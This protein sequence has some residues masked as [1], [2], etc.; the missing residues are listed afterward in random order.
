MGGRGGERGERGC[1]CVEQR[2]QWEDPSA[3]Q[4]DGE[5]ELSQT[6]RGVR[7]VCVGVVLRVQPKLSRPLHAYRG[8]KLLQDPRNLESTAV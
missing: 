6:N 8:K 1:G 5:N 2:E 3:T 4:P 7:G